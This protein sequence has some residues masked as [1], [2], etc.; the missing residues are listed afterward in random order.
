MRFAIMT[1]RIRKKLF[2][3]RIL[4]GIINKSVNTS[5]YNLD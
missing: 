2:I 4:R 1:N 3:R 5:K